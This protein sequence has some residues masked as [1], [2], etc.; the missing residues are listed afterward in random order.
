[1][2]LA[3]LKVGGHAESVQSV[4]PVVRDIQG[5]TA[6]IYYNVQGQR[7]PYPKKGMLV[8][9]RHMDQTGKMVYRKFIY[10]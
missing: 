4:I 3:G 10:E 9:E 1:M 5:P 6:P 7:I 2:G 8:I